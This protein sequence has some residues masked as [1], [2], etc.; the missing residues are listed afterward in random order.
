M[1]KIMALTIFDMKYFYRDFMLIVAIIAPFLLA[2]LFRFGI[3][4]FA[5]FIEDKIVFQPELYTELFA[6]ILLLTVPVMLGMFAAFVILDEQDENLLMY[7]A[8]TPLSQRGY[9]IYRLGGPVLISTCLS[10]TALFLAGYQSVISAYT[11]PVILFSGIEAPLVT[12]FIISFAKNKVEGL[13]VAKAAS[14]LLLV[15]FLYYFV[16]GNWKYL[17]GLLPPFW[18]AAAFFTGIQSSLS[19]TIVNLIIAACTH[20]LAIFL[21][22]KRFASIQ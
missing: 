19:L 8:V 17:G 11:M 7:M 2:L 4:A 6:L 21:L 20:A 16:S 14:V 9:L 18:I 3:P 1:K 15:P 5:T 12:L 13:A 10:V 22:Y